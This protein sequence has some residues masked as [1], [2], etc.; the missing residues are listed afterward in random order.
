MT[1][2]PCKLCNKNMA[3]LSWPLSIDQFFCEKCLWDI[4]KATWLRFSCLSIPDLQKL[5]RELY[6]ENEET[7]KNVTCFLENKI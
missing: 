6:K 3:Q 5:L 4:F 2:Y 1:P 7:M